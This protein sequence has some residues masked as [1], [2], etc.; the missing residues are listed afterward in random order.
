MEIRQT[1][2]A[3]ITGVSATD[4]VFKRPV[5]GCCRGVTAVKYQNVEFHQVKKAKCVD[6]GEEPVQ[7][8]SLYREKEIVSEPDVSRLKG[9]APARVAPAVTGKP[10]VSCQ[11]P[12][13]ADGDMT[14]RELFHGD[15][16]KKG[17]KK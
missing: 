6:A 17:W 7:K 1:R 16:M 3:V 11:M 14:I 12:G 9:A 4:A 2:Q 13:E 8:V 10:A 15:G 5:D